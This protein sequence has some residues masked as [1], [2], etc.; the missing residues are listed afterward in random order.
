[1]AA[2]VFNQLHLEVDEHFSLK[3]AADK[4]DLLT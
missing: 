3:S 4:L 2:G 1:M